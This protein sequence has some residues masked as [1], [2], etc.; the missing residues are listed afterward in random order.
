ML[1][2]PLPRG[3]HM[4]VASFVVAHAA[5]TIEFLVAVF[6][7][8][9]VD[10]YDGPG[11]AV[12]H[13]EILIGDSVVMCG[14]PSGD[15]PARPSMMS[16]YVEDVDAVYAKALAAGGTSKQAP[17]DQFYG[18]RSARVVDPCGNEWSISKILETLTREQIEQRMAELH[19]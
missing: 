3:H 12:A 8:E 16:I 18:H 5:K 9:V 11:G 10:R 6:D 19:R 2:Y 13:A 4:V 7:A 14:E 17:A 15:F 1:S